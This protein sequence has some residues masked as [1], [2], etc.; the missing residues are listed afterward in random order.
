MITPFADA[1]KNNDFIFYNNPKSLNGA[2]IH[3]VN[4]EK[5]MLM[6]KEQITIDVSR[7]DKNI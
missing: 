1:K 5:T 7:I 4:K 6:G 3:K 2:I